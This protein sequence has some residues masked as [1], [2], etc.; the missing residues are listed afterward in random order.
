MHILIEILLSII[1]TLCMLLRLKNVCQGKEYIK[2]FLLIPLLLLIFSFSLFIIPEIFSGNLPI[3]MCFVYYNLIVIAL[4]EL[5]GYIKQ[6]DKRN[7]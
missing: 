5:I 4:V 3:H 7:N 1:L 6:K 2:I